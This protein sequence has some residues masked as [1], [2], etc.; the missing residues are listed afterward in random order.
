MT[1]PDFVFK[2]AGKAFSFVFSSGE[3]IYSKIMLSEGQNIIVVIL[4]NNVRQNINQS[5]KHT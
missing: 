5:R 1:R 3:V 4:V 2:D